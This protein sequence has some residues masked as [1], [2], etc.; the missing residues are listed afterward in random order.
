MEDKLYIGYDD[1]SE[2][3]DIPCL[4]VVRYFE[5]GYDEINTFYEQEAEELYKKLV[6]ISGR[7]GERV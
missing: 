1:G 4:T 3:G 2:R 5:T 7:T 6:N